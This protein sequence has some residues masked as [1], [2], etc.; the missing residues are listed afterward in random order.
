MN[1]VSI[2]PLMKIG[3]RKL[4]RMEFVR[5]LK[6]RR[7]NLHMLHQLFWECTLKCNLSCLHCGSDCKAIEKQHDMPLVNFIS[8]LDEIS[9]VVEPQRILVITTGG[10]PLVRP[11]IV[12]CGREISSRGFMWGMVTNGL[13]LSEEMLDELIDA[14]LQTIAISLDGF[15]DYHNWMRGN[16]HSFEKAVSAIKALTRKN[17]VWDVISCVNQRNIGRLNEFKEFLKSIGVKKWR[18]FTVFPEGRAKENMELYL[19][20]SQMKW[21]MDFISETRKS[22]KSIQLNYSCEG[23]LGAYEYEVRDYPFFCQAGIN[24]ASILNNGDISG[25]LSIRP[26]YCQ[27]NIYHDNFMDVWQNGFH[28]YRNRSWMKIG[29]CEKCNVWRYCEGGSFHLRDGK[30]K[31]SICHW[32]KLSR[33]V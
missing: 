27:G 3:F 24:V 13:L 4:L 15:D 8:V 32:N 21:L 25:C 2:L 16:H 11:D 12:Q 5:R 14:G 1:G 20:S 33:H 29:P 7:T 18:I 17:I 31:L 30:G 26:D 6:N 19:D 28:V 22:D 23:F 10:E 9:K